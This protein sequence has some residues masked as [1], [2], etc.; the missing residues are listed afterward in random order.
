MQT[1]QPKWALSRSPIL[2]NSQASVAGAR[3]MVETKFQMCFIPGISRRI[4]QKKVP[5]QNHSLEHC[6]GDF[7]PKPETLKSWDWC[8][9]FKDSNFEKC[10]QFFEMVDFGLGDRT[11]SVSAKTISKSMIVLLDFVSPFPHPT[12]TSRHRWSSQIAYSRIHIQL[13]SPHS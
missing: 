13:Q 9:H 2:Q 6:F 11:G 4:C 5:K 1:V 8:G 10:Q 3:R 12:L 7:Y